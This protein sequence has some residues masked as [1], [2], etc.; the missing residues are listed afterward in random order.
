MRDEERERESQR[1]QVQ[2]IGGNNSPDSLDSMKG[3]RE[4]AFLRR[5]HCQLREGKK[6]TIF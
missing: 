1:Q 5:L 4:R 2:A 6:E 3:E